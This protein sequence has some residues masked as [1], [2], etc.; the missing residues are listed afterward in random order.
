[1]NYSNESDY[2]WFVR[3]ISGHVL[4]IEEGESVN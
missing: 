4:I 2:N 3:K 1:M